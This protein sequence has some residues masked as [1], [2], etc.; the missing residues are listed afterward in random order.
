[1]K[2][3]ALEFSSDQRSVAVGEFP[4]GAVLAESLE[5]GSRE[6]KPFAMIEAA[7]REA[8]WEREQIECLAVGLGPGSYT[9]IRVAISL[10]QGWQLAQGVRLL[11]ISSVD[12][13]AAQA[14]ADGIHGIVS[15]VIDAQRNEFYLATYEIQAGNSRVLAPLHLATH[16]EVRERESA[17]DIFAGP[18]VNRWFPAGRVLFPRAAMLAQLAAGR[19]DFVSG[20]R[21]EPIYLR[22]TSFIKAPPPR[23]IG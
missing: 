10:A 13:L 14:Q 7:L 1:M 21:L 4:A 20:D 12:C 15:I 8:R 5:A 11:G 17:G 23:I 3:L 19:T 18:E 16:A 9:G 6:M 2:I 22:K